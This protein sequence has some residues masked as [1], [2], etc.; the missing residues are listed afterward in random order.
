[1]S[2]NSDVEQEIAG[3]KERITEH[4]AE[5]VAIKAHERYDMLDDKFI[6]LIKSEK[7]GILACDTAIHDLRINSSNQTVNNIVIFVS[8]VLCI[9]SVLCF[10]SAL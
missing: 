10:V 3:Y 9:S 6:E 2:S 7:D 1:M 5:I 4:R 8:S